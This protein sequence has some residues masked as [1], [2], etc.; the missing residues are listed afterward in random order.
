MEKGELAHW[1]DIATF[2]A[3]CE[4]HTS[5]LVQTTITNST[6]AIIMQRMP[7][8]FVRLS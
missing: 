8:T 6:R 7:V 5:L 1:S 2:I 3:G 4:R